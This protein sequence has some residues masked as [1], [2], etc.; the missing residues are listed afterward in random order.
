M[1]IYILKII[2]FYLK[3]TKMLRAKDS[4]LVNDELINEYM[5]LLNEKSQKCG[6]KTYCLGSYALITY[7]KFV[8][9][10]RDLRRLHDKMAL[11]NIEK[12]II[13][14]HVASNNHWII[15]IAL[16][17][18][19]RVVVFD[20][21]EGNTGKDPW[22]IIPDID[23]LRE[24]L[25]D[26]GKYNNNKK[27]VEI[28]WL[29]E[30]G[31]YD[32]YQDDVISCGIYIIVIAELQTQYP[33]HIVNNIN[34]YDVYANRKRINSNISNKQTFESVESSNISYETVDM[35]LFTKPKTH[36]FNGKGQRI[37]ILAS[38][39]RDPKRT[40][41]IIS[42]NIKMKLMGHLKKIKNG[43]RFNKKVYSSI[44]A[45]RDSLVVD[46]NIPRRI[47]KLMN[48]LF[49][50]LDHKSI[51]KKKLFEVAIACEKK[52][53]NDY[54]LERTLCEALQRYKIERV[55]I[56][57]IEKDADMVKDIKKFLVPSQDI[58]PFD[59]DVDMNLLRMQDSLYCL[60]NSFPENFLD[61]ILYDNIHDFK[62]DFDEAYIIDINFF[63]TDN[64]CM[65]DENE[66]NL[67][68][69]DIMHNCH[70]KLILFKPINNWSKVNL[71]ISDW[72]FKG[73]PSEKKHKK[74]I[75]DTQRT[76]EEILK[77][78]YPLDDAEKI[79][80]KTLDLV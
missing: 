32:D 72:S 50:I 53:N 28:P 40:H 5:S 30:E 45:D 63:L 42:P 52:Q 69:S 80:H 21:L 26:Y 74:N 11:E 37:Q 57:I 31:I 23:I 75:E 2:S 46:N 58:F 62:H 43:E 20:S 4:Y 70:G 67:I 54:I 19:H 59:Q 34:I 79:W 65:L 35:S 12:L 56:Y 29:F 39:D 1:Y 47:H 16:I 76:Y 8:Q 51:D 13:P 77:C 18:T 14:C 22:K 33:D 38:I 73:Q 41:S 7:K 61:I 10:S 55:R 48:Y 68:R 15:F 36:C 66:L 60:M 17:K 71:Q 9:D 27:L 64:F 25:I 24:M 44:S 78:L 6:K 3:N 49:S